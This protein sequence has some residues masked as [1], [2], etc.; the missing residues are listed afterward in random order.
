MGPD[1]Q[2]LLTKVLVKMCHMFLLFYTLLVLGVLMPPRL[3]ACDLYHGVHLRLQGSYYC[4]Q[5]GA[6]LAFLLLRALAQS[7]EDG[8]LAVCFCGW[9]SLP[10]VCSVGCWLP[11]LHGN[12]RGCMMLPI[13][14]TLT[15]R[16]CVCVHLSLCLPW[17]QRSSSE[18]FWQSYLVL[19]IPQE[20]LCLSI[21]SPKPLSSGL[22]LFNH[23]VFNTV[24]PAETPDRM[25][26]TAEIHHCCCCSF[27]NLFNSLDFSDQILCWRLLAAEQLSFSSF[28]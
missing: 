27:L 15:W 11:F 21:C 6:S 24:W 10:L 23:I 14:I 8:C 17:P 22:L 28:S 16:C 20:F 1:S 5:R 26:S 12:E 2:L 9:F 18:C 7:L 13:A 25:W 19:G 3:I 4:L